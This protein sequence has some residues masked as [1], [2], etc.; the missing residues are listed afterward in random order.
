MDAEFNS[1]HFSNDTEEDDDE[2]TDL[3]LETIVSHSRKIDQLAYESQC[4]GL[5]SHNRFLIIQSNAS[6][7]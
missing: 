7:H 6:F 4:L 1:Q 5:N 2:V 3:S